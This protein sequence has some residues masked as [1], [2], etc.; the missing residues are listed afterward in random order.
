MAILV[1]NKDTTLF[2]VVYPNSGK[3]TVILLHGGPGA[4]DGLGP[5]AEFLSPDFQ[6][7]S[8]HQRG[9]LNS[10]CFSHN[11]A[12]ARYISDIDRIAGHFNLPKFHLFGHSWGGLYAQLYA[13]KRPGTLLSLFLCS[14]AS[15]TGWQWLKMAMEI[16]RF[17]RK[18]STR[19][20]WLAMEKNALLGLLG[21]DKGYQKFHTQFCL[22][23]NKGYRV[24]D[25]VPMMVEHAKAKPINRT[26][27]SVLFHPR[28]RKEPDPG[29]NITVTYGDD[30]IYGD[31]PK[32]VRKRYP[33]ADFFTILGSGHFPWLHNREAFFNLLA[34]H[35]HTGNSSRDDLSAQVL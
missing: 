22:N 19:L 32:Y 30:D 34:D 26:N 28:L 16:R 7:I 31:S 18:R 10:P 29:F 17:H 2:T 5:V 24:K 23:C 20:E 13:Q 35:Y 11:Y 21:S 8:F 27:R 15:G 9:T 14:P 3:E 12:I 25:R 33:T 6:V 4:P 1:R